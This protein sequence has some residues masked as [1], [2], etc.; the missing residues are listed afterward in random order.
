MEPHQRPPDFLRDGIW[1]DEPIDLGDL[2]LRYEAHHT[3][4]DALAL[5]AYSNLFRRMI[6]MDGITVFDSGGRLL[7]YNC[8][9]HQQIIG[10]PPHQIVGGA[11]RRAFEVLCDEVGRTLV[12]ALY[13]SR[14][15]AAECRESPRSR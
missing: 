1:L 15:G 11:R 10:S 7:G 3:E 12:A 13:R 8:F 2:A 4:S 9:I 5:I 6:G 14:D